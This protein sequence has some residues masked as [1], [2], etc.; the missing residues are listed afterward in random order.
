MLSACLTLAA[1]KAG[2]L[3]LPFSTLLA[4]LK[5]W[6]R[7]PGSAAKRIAPERIG[8]AV[9]VAGGA[10]PG[11]SQCLARALAA[12]LMMAR[13]GHSSELKIGVRR[14]PAGEFMAHAWLEYGG[15]VVVGEF[16]LDKYALLAIPRNARHS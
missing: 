2:L 6:D 4:V 14:G 5:R 15:R 9:G 13:A 8:W 7:R 12:R 16:E 11:G 1:I 10:I 3:L